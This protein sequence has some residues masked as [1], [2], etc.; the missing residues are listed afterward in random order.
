MKSSG[1]LT[2][3]KI[4][5]LAIAK[6]AVL[7]IVVVAAGALIFT[8]REWLPV[9]TRFVPSYV[10]GSSQGPPEHTDPGG[11]E[12]S[13]H[14]EAESDEGE[15]AQDG[16]TRYDHEHDEA[17]AITL[18]KQARG[19]IG[20]RLARVELKPFER[21]ITVPGIVV[22]RPGWSMLEITAPMTGVVTRI[23]PIQGE[24]IQPGQP[25]F[26]V[27]LTHEDLLQVQTEFL[28]TIE[29]LDVIG[30][31][32]AR[33]EKVSADGVIAG[34]TLLER[35]YEQ[36]KQEAALRAQRQA[37][38]LHGLSQD[39]VDKIV[40]SRTLLQSLTI[41]AP[42][43]EAAGASETHPLQVQQLKVSQGKYVA[44]GDT[45][46]TLVDYGELYIEGRAFEQDIR[47][48][49]Q[50]AAARAK[51]SAVLG[52]KSAGGEELLQG[53][54]IL[55]LSD[56]VDS[57]SRAFHFYVEIPNR[58]LRDDKTPGGRRFVYWQFKPG[59]RTQV[60]VP[61]EQWIDRIV[62]PVEAVA[63]EGAEAYVF[64]AND[65]HF[66]RRPVH[67]EYRDQDWVVIANDGALKLGA[68]VA[69]SAAHQ[70][71]LALKSKAGG[72]VDPHAG[73]NH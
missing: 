72:G 48:I 16:K 25:L 52:S 50:A 15:H 4:R 36:Q 10:A 45:L 1:W 71:Q 21:T 58:V 30:R 61:V 39:Q 46:C 31:E 29:E 69:T 33:L 22:E 20:L 53:L 23:Y 73:H 9:V 49:N 2:I 8:C 38:L 5:S 12:H 64:E 62:L 13:Q 17:A 41:C 11:D 6:W 47:A 65:D 68:T 55:Y 67:V 70:V 66:D 63:Q 54:R 14:G 40:A 3:F 44:A 24:A 60:R 37:L 18:S 43:R 7:A 57:E 56:K 19:N 27:R 42:V 26:E 51:V 28:R 32:V 59:Q 35:K 34:K